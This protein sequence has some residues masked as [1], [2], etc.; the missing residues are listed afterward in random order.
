MV[1]HSPRQQ[2][3]E[4]KQ[5]ADDYGCFVREKGGIFLVFR[6]MHDRAVFLGKRSTPE[7]LRTF[8]CKVTNFH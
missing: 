1:R 7:A 6:R 2:L 3:K 8:V 5:I 4:A